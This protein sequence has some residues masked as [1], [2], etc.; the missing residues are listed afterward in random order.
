MKERTYKK[1]RD[2]IKV[3][4]IDFL[5]IHLSLN[6]YSA[7]WKTG[8]ILVLHQINAKY[9]QYNMLKCIL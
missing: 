5:V 2:L 9:N 1:K 3:V 4:N 6:N 8:H 7:G